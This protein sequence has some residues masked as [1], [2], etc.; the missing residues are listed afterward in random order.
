[1]PM[2]LPLIVAALA[3]LPALL[4]LPRPALAGHD[5]G[6]VVSFWAFSHDGRHLLLYVE[7]ENRGA[8]LAVKAVGKLR[9]LH[10]IP[11][12]GQPPQAFLQMPPLSKYRFVDGGVKG[13]DSPDGKAKILATPAKT[14]FQVFMTNGA[15]MVPMFSLPLDKDPTG[16][17]FGTATLKEIVWSSNGRV[18]ALIVNQTLVSEYGANVD[19]V[20]SF[21][22]AP[23]FKKLK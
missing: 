12:G 9:S 22:T 5:T 16:T 7:D 23:Y 8:V 17:Q 3:L 20:I 19:Q 2:R 6:A 15:K 10:E 18:G 4:A 14:S 13:P 11:T 1:M 21:P